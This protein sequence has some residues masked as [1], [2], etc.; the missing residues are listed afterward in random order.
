MTSVNVP[1]NPATVTVVTAVLTKTSEDGFEMELV[2][3]VAVIVMSASE[4][5]VPLKL[6]VAVPSS[7]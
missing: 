6:P 7:V 2:S 3:A 1:V 4:K 5:A